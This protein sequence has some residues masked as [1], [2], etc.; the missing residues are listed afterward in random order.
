MQKPI[1]LSFNMVSAQDKMKHRLL[2]PSLSAPFFLFI[3]L[4]DG[5]VVDKINLSIGGVLFNL[6]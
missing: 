4:L 3:N 5:N 1:K 2:S 6:F